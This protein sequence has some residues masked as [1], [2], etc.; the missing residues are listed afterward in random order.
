MQHVFMMDDGEIIGRILS[1]GEAMSVKLSICIVA[2]RSYDEVIEAV[3][4]IERFTSD[5]LKKKIYIVDNSQ[6]SSITPERVDFE[7]HI[8]QYSDVVYLELEENIGFGKG[9]NYILTRLDSQ[10]HAIVNPDIVFKEDSFF[11]LIS[12]MENNPDVGMCVPK[13]VDLEGELQLAYRKNPTIIDMFIR[14]FCSKLFPKRIAKHT[15]Q[16]KDYSKPFQVPFAQGSFLIVKT[17]LF[18]ELEGFD[19]KF[20]MY[21]EDADLCR[22]VNECSCVMYCP[23]TEVV[24]KWEKASHKN[25]KLFMIHLKSMGYYFKKWG[26]KL[27]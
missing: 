19:D 26:W 8:E 11:K 21:L 3:D 13:L 27:W 23:D 22:R 16:D 25:M 24:H 5:K 18:K 15:L 2:Y 4:S 10:Y 7:K 20:F 14:M 17:E 12:Y 6:I 9:H 1:G